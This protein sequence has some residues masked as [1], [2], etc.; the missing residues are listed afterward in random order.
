MGKIGFR[1]AL[2]VGIAGLSAPAF[3]TEQ[4]YHPVSPTFGGNPSNG[5]FLLS[6]AQSQGEGSKSGNQGPDLSGLDSALANIGGA[7][8][9]GG[10]GG[11][12]NGGANG[13]N[14]ANGAANAN[15]RSN[16]RANPLGTSSGMP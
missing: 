13:N 4:V 10:G 16:L 7:G 14:G 9:G 15:F 2:V 1:V 12:G 3:A 5:T 8:G 11:S 6:T